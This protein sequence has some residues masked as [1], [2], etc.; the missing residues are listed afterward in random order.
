VT[1]VAGEIMDDA[2][3]CGDGFRCEDIPADYGNYTCDKGWEGPNYGITNFDNI[4]LAMLTVFQCVTMEGWTDMLYFVSDMR[5]AP[6][7]T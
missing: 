6:H 3:P 4:G 2:R 7:V 1:P 5:H